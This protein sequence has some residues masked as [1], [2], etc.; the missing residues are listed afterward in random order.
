M[1]ARAFGTLAIAVLVLSVSGPARA[2]FSGGSFDDYANGDT[3]SS[4]GFTYGE[5][6]GG[7]PN[8]PAWA[9]SGLF[10]SDPNSSPDP[11]YSDPSGGGGSSAASDP[12]PP[13]VAPPDPA[14][15]PAPPD[16]G[17]PADPVPPPD[18]AAA[19]PP[20]DPAP[21]PA[22]PD[23]PPP[24]P[25]PAPVADPPP[26][27]EDPPPPP[28]PPDPPPVADPAPP[29][30]DPTPPQ[31]PPPAPVVAAKPAARIARIRFNSGGVD[32]HVVNQPGQ[33]GSTFI[34]TDPEGLLASPWP[35]FSSPQSAP[36]GA[37]NTLLP[38]VP[39]A[40]TGAGS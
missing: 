30:A 7:D 11:A 17:P 3:S 24:P 36:V 6:G 37:Q 14:P 28:P 10:I 32:A 9:N 39:A 20:P 25:D 15:I 4:G 33:A 38:P 40:Q 13:D 19:P 12:P 18:P 29:A 21:P 16:P 2:C 35:D 1:S 31:P 34:W 22:P 8:G 23:P 5:L 27:A 26:P